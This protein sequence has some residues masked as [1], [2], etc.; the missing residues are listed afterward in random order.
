[1]LKTI[2]NQ[3]KK[4]TGFLGKIVSAAMKKGNSFAYDTILDI[5]EIKDQDNVFEIGY[6]HGIGIER[7]L[8]KNNCSISGID[9]SELMYKEAA[10]RNKRHIELNNAKLYFG[11]FLT[12]K[13]DELRFD[14]I[15]CINVIYFW[16]NLEKPFLAIRNGLKNNGSFCFYMAHSDE[17]NKHKFTKDDIFNKYSIENVVEKLKLVGFSKIDY[18]YQKGYFVKCEK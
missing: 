4:P 16:D 5:L 3:F 9:F 13:L 17:L 8:S 7:I 6:G 18:Q 14:K 15:F 10:K 1:M 12:F 11:D 2:G